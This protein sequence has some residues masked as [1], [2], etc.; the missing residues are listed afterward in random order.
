M[1]YLSLDPRDVITFSPSSSS[2]LAGSKSGSERHKSDVRK[3]RTP[4]SHCNCQL[5]EYDS[6]Y[7]L[8]V[9]AK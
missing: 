6:E 3:I 8:C 2:V 5:E 1:A 4:L 9:Y 7:L